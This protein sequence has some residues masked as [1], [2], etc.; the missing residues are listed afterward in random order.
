MPRTGRA[1]HVARVNRRQARS[2]PF[3]A[4]FRPPP[5]PLRPALRPRPGLGPPGP[6]MRWKP[7]PL[8]AA[9][10][11]DA[12]AQLVRRWSLQALHRQRADAVQGR[13]R[14]GHVPVLGHVGDV[15]GVALPTSWVAAD[16]GSGLFHA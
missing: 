14:C 8:P 5:R 3:S 11:R 16:G 1:A 12:A 7:T 13:A 15:P 10:A 2:R 6:A 9:A 4:P